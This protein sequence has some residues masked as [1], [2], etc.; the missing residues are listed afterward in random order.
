[1]PTWLLVINNNCQL[2]FVVSAQPSSGAFKARNLNLVRRER[3]W[4]LRSV[5]QHRLHLMWR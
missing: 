1:M 5:F 4:L 3:S 2:R